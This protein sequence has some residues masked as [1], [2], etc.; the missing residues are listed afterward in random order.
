MINEVEPLRDDVRSFID[1]AMRLLDL[2]PHQ[3][4]HPRFGVVDVVPFVALDPSRHL[5]ASQLRDETARWLADQFAV[6]VFL[7]GELNDGTSRTLPEVRR[8]AFRELEP[9]FGPPAPNSRLGASALGARGVLVAWNLWLTGV[10]LAEAKE[11]ARAVRRREVRAL[12]LSIPPFVQISCNLVA[13]LVVGPSRVY[14]HVA[15]LMRSGTIDHAEL[16][17]LVP[18]AVLAAEDPSR[19]RELGLSDD[20][21]IEA[22]LRA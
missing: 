22:R 18:V 10:E 11:I 4:V 14:D 19:H 6:P 15:S 5:E 3:G 21:T 17:G 13:P 9:D 7:Y 1:A 20:T 8:H 12:A 16:V 2:A